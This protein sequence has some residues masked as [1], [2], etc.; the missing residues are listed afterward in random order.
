MAKTSAATEAS[1]KTKAACAC[2]LDAICNHS[3]LAFEAAEKNAK[4]KASAEEARKNI[5]GDKK[6]KAEEALARSPLYEHIH[7]WHFLI[8]MIER[9]WV[10]GSLFAECWPMGP[11]RARPQE[12]GP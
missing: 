11:I 3:C 6:K 7:I 12:P 9:K 4:E 8:G 1:S 10:R 2:S 5:E